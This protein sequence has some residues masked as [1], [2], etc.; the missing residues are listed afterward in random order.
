MINIKLVPLIIAFIII[1]EHPIC[2]IILLL[3]AFGMAL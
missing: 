3:A 2:G 1:D